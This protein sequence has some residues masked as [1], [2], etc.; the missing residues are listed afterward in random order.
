MA[1]ESAPAGSS[2]A[3]FGQPNFENTSMFAKTPPAVSESK[4]MKSEVPANA[5]VEDLCIADPYGSDCL[6]AIL[7]AF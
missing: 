1:N 7:F 6:T 5:R 4:Q 3:P 2:S